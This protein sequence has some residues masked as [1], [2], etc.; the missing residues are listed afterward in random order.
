MS[1]TSGEEGGREGGRARTRTGRD[2][3]S[4]LSIPTTFPSPTSDLTGDSSTPVTGTPPY[5]STVVSFFLVWGRRGPSV[6]TRSDVPLVGV[7]GS[8]RS[9]GR[10]PVGSRPEDD[11]VGRKEGC[12]EGTD[13]HRVDPRRGGATDLRR[14]GRE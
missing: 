7:K 6:G 1:R 12:P 3:T 11:G 4:V 10:V 2:K 5:R 8:G 13:D 14:R 9:Q